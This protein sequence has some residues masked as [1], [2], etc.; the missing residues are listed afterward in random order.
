MYTNLITD[1]EQRIETLILSGEF[2]DPEFVFY[3]E[4]LKVKF[5]RTEIY[6]SL[7]TNISN[8]CPETNSLDLVNIADDAAAHVIS[9]FQNLHSTADYLAQ[10]LNKC[11]NPQPLEEKEVSLYSIYNELGKAT[12]SGE[13]SS[14]IHAIE[15][16]KRT[17]EWGFV[18]LLVNMEKHRRIIDTDFDENCQIK[19]IFFEGTRRVGSSLKD[20]EAEE[21]VDSLINNALFRGYQLS[22]NKDATKQ[23][24]MSLPPKVDA[25]QTLKSCR[26]VFM[27]SFAEIGNEMLTSLGH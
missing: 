2:T 12:Y 16:F 4:S 22:I 24:L 21:L 5:D 18:N 15:K 14:V 11:I 23:Y 20:K 10:I 17:K 8:K 9:A 1:W 3:L 6:M 7:L 27:D 13:F 25:L 26:T 19:F